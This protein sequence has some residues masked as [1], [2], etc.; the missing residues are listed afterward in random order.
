[1]FASRAGLE[2]VR[3]LL[4]FDGNLKTLANGLNPPKT[5]DPTGMIY[6]FNS[7]GGD[8]IDPVKGPTIVNNATLDD[9]LCQEQFRRLG[10]K[11]S[12][13]VLGGRE[14][15]KTAEFMA[16]KSSF[17]LFAP[18]VDEIPY[19]GSAGAVP[20]KWV[21]ITYKQNL[22]GLLPLSST[23]PTNPLDPKQGTNAQVCWD[24][25]KESVAAPGT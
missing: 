4:A 6:I 25:Q 21:R 8:N 24:G 19:A 15:E 11:F 2:N 16:D 20:F 23:N 3:M 13:G 14:N 10:L 12:T 5:G 17:K 22:M 1:Y 9:E 18:A 7:N